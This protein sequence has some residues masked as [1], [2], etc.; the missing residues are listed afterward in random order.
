MAINRSKDPPTWLKV[1]TTLEKNQPLPT[2]THQNLTDEIFECL[3]LKESVGILIQISLKY[4]HTAK[5]IDLGSGLV[6]NRRQSISWTNWPTHNASYLRP[7]WMK[8]TETNSL[9]FN[10]KLVIIGLGNPL[11][12]NMILTT[13][14]SFDAL[15]VVILTTSS[16]VS[17]ECVVKVAFLSHWSARRKTGCNP[18]P[19]WRHQMETFSE[20]LALCAGNSPVTGEFP[21]QR[22]MTRGFDA[23]LNLRLN[24]RLS[25][26]SLGWWFETPSGSLWRQCNVR[27]RCWRSS[28]T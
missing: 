13:F 9:V 6:P 10:L 21:T 23:F 5:S 3:S 22:P 28:L 8:C 11:T 14:S 4:V 24:K 15:E 17:D 7:Q 20:L 1:A 12:G 2:R 27:N 25:K 18:L 16:A 19:W 26:Q